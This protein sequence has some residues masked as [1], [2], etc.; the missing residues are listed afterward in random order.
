MSN[1]YELS[2][3]EK[4]FDQASQWIARLDRKLSSSEERELQAWMAESPQNETVLLEMAQL[5]DKIDTLGR[6]STLF[7]KPERVV[8]PKARWFAV[9]SFASLLLM[10]VT[11]WL[12]WPLSANIPP[13]APAEFVYQ[14][15]V[16]ERSAI[17][18]GDGSIIQLNTNSRIRVNYTEQ[19]RLLILE[20][21]EV[22]VKVAKDKNRPLSVVAGTQIV[23]AV[24]TEFNIEI[25]S[26]QKIELV[27]LEGKVK[28][29]V[30]ESVASNFEAE[31]NLLPHGNKTLIAGETM[32]LGDSKE[33]I[34][35]VSSED[36]E[37]SLSWRS[38]NL[39]F[40]G[41]PLEEAVREVERYTSVEFVFLDENLKKIRVAGLFRAG[42]VE[43]LL[44][45]LRENFDIAYQFV[46]DQK[47]V[48][49]SK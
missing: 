21:G 14:T 13:G 32:M 2:T 12:L 23:Q 15:D 22:N 33:E 37:V 20:R 31:A 19:H 9:A 28:V 38:G 35:E 26:D 10:A 46:D 7:P 29:G 18:L 39:V 30:R 3:Q 11:L 44:A 40:R 45:T 25:T 36:I 43:G 16:G 17:T 42:D 41:E 49:S 27:V 1:V 4:R 8:A 5:W 47:V 34:K 48:L 24:G 6:L